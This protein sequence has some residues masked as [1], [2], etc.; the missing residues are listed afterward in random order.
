[1]GG[2]SNFATD[3]G[4]TPRDAGD[5][6][7]SETVVLTSLQIEQHT[8]LTGHLTSLATNAKVQLHRGKTADTI[9]L[10][11]VVPPNYT[12]LGNL[13]STVHEGTSGDGAA[14]TQLITSRQLSLTTWDDYTGA[15]EAHPNVQPT[16]WLWCLVKV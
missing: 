2:T 5:Q 13:S 9:D 7:G 8:H 11:P 6:D 10:P 12:E 3:S 15:A 16:T 14:G 1:V 4:I